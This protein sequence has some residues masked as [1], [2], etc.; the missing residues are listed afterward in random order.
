MSLSEPTPDASTTNAV[1]QA[2]A[3]G[4]LLD[5]VDLLHAHNR[6]YRSA[7]NDQRLVDLRHQAFAEAREAPSSAPSV[8]PPAWSRQPLGPRL[9]ARS[10]GL[11]AVEDG[12]VDADALGRGIQSHGCLLLP[13]A[14][15]AARVDR[16]HNGIDQAYAARDVAN[17]SEGPAPT[18]GPYAPFRPAPPHRIGPTRVWASDTG[19]LLTFDAPAV[20]FD[21][22]DVLDALGVLTAITGYLGE[23]PALS[24]D[25][26]T[27]RRIA[28]DHIGDW[29]QDGAFLGDD[30]RAVNV[31]MALTD[32]GVDAPGLDVVPRRV[33]HL[34]PTGTDGSY[35]DW[36]IGDG[37]VRREAGPNGVVR[38]EFHAGDVLLFDDR[39]V[40]RTAISPQMTVPRYAIECWFFAPSVYPTDRIPL[41]V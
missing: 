14:V 16:L 22:L 24:F 41:V 17:A 18:S 31:W 29:H 13:R 33:D 12:T 19:G 11:A 32:C 9:V 26:C 40:H 21:L 6:L 25:K 34:L 36:S 3:D 5:A 38:P 35:F 23:R 39:F 37:A 27:L 15:D 30:I 4:R 7:E 8:W 10:D 1:D 28:V 20:L 2:V